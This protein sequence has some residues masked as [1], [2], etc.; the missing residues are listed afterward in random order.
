MKSLVIEELKP[1]LDDPEVDL[2]FLDESG[3]GDPRP[4]RRWAPQGEKIRFPY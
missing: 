1:L 3:E 4:K 2:W